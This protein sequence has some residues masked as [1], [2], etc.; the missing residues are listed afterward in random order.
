MTALPLT[1]PDSRHKFSDVLQNPLD[2]GPPS[3][4]TYTIS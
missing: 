2:S 4:Y 1:L 3:R